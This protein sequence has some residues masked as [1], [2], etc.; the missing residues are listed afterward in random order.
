MYWSLSAHRNTKDISSVAGTHYRTN[1][2]K[3]CTSSPTS[4]LEEIP[5]YGRLTLPVLIPLAAHHEESVSLQYSSYTNDLF[6]QHQLSGREIK[7]S[8]HV[9]CCAVHEAQSNHPCLNFFFSMPEVVNQS[10]HKVACPSTVWSHSKVNTS[11]M[12]HTCPCCT[13]L[14]QAIQLPEQ[15]W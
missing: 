15:R 9:L 6:S 10:P 4:R 8:I 3:S 5:L 13:Q 11:V 7:Y 12:L 1:N 2:F 14:Q